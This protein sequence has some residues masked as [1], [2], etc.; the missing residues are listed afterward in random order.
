MKDKEKS[1]NKNQRNA[2]NL[3][4]KV[5]LLLLLLKYNSFLKTTS[6]NLIYLIESSNVMINND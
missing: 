5:H 1:I 4:K 2:E 6:Q 3:K